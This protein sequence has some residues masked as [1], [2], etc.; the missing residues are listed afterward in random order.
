MTCDRCLAV[1]QDDVTAF[2]ERV[3]AVIQPAQCRQYCDCGIL[4]D[5]GRLVTMTQIG[6]D[7]AGWSD[8][9]DMELSRRGYDS[10]A[11]TPVFDFISSEGP[12][13]RTVDDEVYAM[14]EAGWG[15]DEVVDAL[16]DRDGF[17]SDNELVDE[18][19]EED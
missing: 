16:E 8:E 4:R 5:N 7:Y 17:W 10:V 2:P 14:F 19:G 13:A 11:D 3:I 12:N 6:R 9:L 15:P 18:Y 1:V